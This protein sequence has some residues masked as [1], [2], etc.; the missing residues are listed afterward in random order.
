[1]TVCASVPSL[2]PFT[3]VNDPAPGDA[4]AAIVKKSTPPPARVTTTVTPVYVPTFTVCME[5]LQ[6]GYVSAV[7]ATGGFTVEVIDRD[8][9]GL[10]VEFI[11]S[12]GPALEEV[13]V[14][15]QLKNTTT[16]K[17]DPGKAT[18]TYRFNARE[19]YLHLAK[20]RELV[21][22]FLIVMVTNPDQT[23]WTTCSHDE[24]KVDHCCYW[25]NLEG[26]DVPDVEKPSVKV[27]TGNVFDAA[28][29]TAMFKR[30]ENGQAI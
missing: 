18:F 26:N 12:R 14:R 30:V 25:A 9:F 24:L 3:G 27:P 2:L 6:V 7:A 4:A 1:V 29:L 15:A 5:Q 13:T 16:I 22:A 23:K 17:P 21:K 10:D 20:K 19:H 11:K 28:A 8:T